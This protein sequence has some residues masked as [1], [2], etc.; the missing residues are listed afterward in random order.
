MYGDARKRSRGFPKPQ[1]DL[2][3]HLCVCDS[4]LADLLPDTTMAK[5][6]IQTFSDCS[7]VSHHTDAYDSMITIQELQKSKI[8]IFFG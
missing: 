1:I 2:P 7:R 5:G 8:A 3:L 4:E 6:L